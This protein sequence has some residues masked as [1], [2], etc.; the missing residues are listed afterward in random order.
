MTTVTPYG[1]SQTGTFV[2]PQTA[3][4]TP[5]TVQQ[6][7][8]QTVYGLANASQLS[9]EPLYSSA[10]V[11]AVIVSHNLAS[12]RIKETAGTTVFVKLTS[13]TQPLPDGLTL[14][15]NFGTLG[16]NNIPGVGMPADWNGFDLPPADLG[17]VS[18]DFEKI[19][20]VHVPPAHSNDTLIF[21]AFQRGTSAS[22]DRWS[23]GEPCD[24]DPNDPR[25]NTDKNYRMDLRKYERDAYREIK[26][27]TL[28]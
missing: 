12:T 1:T 9:G 21:K 14:R 3:P 24:F 27:P 20:I 16:C 4:Q 15:G 8:S 19:F 23:A 13:N 5:A 6:Q 18:N 7:L 22:P 2:P 10:H 11:N 25:V 26:N 17:R 28:N